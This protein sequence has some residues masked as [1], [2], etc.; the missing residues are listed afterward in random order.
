MVPACYNGEMTSVPAD[1][2]FQQV[3]FVLCD[4]DGVVWLRRQAL[5]GAADAIE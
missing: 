1:A 3:R 2:D 5:P 4:L